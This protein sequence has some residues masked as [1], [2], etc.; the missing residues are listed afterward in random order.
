MSYGW[1]NSKSLIM[2]NTELSWNCCLLPN[3]WQNPN[4]RNTSREQLS[5][6]STD[7][8]LTFHQDSQNSQ[9]SNNFC[10]LLL[11][12]DL[13]QANP[14]MSLEMFF[15][16]NNYWN[17]W[18]LEFSRDVSTIWTVILSGLWIVQAPGPAFSRS[19]FLLIHVHVWLS[20]NCI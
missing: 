3:T 16:L 6:I 10:S 1:C 2:I 11:K 17:I 12:L 15:F 18:N 20:G 9:I 7:M 13:A 4:L 5:F 14:V 8:F 19:P